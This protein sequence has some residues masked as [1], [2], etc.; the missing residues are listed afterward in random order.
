MGLETFFKHPR[1]TELGKIKIGGLGQER[2]SAKGG[3]YRQPVKFDHFVIT[4]MHRDKAGRLIP[5]TELMKQLAAEYGS[6]PDNDAATEGVLVL[7]NGNKRVLRQIPVQV[8]SNEP[9]DIQQ[10]AYV[11]YGGKS[12]AARSDGDTVTWFNDPTT[13]RKLQEPKAEPWDD[14]YLELEDSRGNKLFK[15]HTVFNCVVAAKE[16]RFGGVYKL[17]TTSVITGGQLYASML[18][19]RTRTFGV[20]MGL[21]L[22]LVVR[23]MLVSPKGETT[24]VYVVHLELHGESLAAIQQQA[25]GQMKV[26]AENRD[27]IAVVQAQYKRLLAPP[28]HE[29]EPQDIADI[30][31]EFQPETADDAEP[32]PPTT[33]DPLLA[34]NETEPKVEP[35]PA[36]APEQ[37]DTGAEAGLPIDQE[38]IADITAEIRALKWNKPQV[39]KAIIEAFPLCAKPSTTWASADILGVMHSDQADKFLGQLRDLRAAKEERT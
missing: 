14:K 37:S 32:E 8:L 21:P 28:G 7:A 11:W 26:F 18:E 6:E 19:L 2:T 35:E 17:R 22:R 3:T 30:N 15:T 33:P 36:P 24:T 5:D 39:C 13:G 12:C 29:S 25:L 16:A 31:M 9:D 27:Q 20:L 10:T 38:Q 23:P 1:M 34:M 4:T